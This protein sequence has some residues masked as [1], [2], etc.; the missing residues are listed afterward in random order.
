MG[1]L[2]F[3]DLLT[4]VGI[5]FVPSLGSCEHSRTGVLWT[6][7]PFSWVNAC[8][9][10]AGSRVTPEHVG[11]LPR[12]FPQRPNP[13]TVPPSSRPPGTCCLS[14]AFSRLRGCEV[15][16]LCDLNTRSL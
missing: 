14:A 8:S 11:E 3:A 6:P 4:S 5:E 7:F 13:A 2:C 12:C 16:S 15:A 1:R 9:G 10:T